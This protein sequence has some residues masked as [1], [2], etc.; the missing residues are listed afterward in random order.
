MASDLKGYYGGDALNSIDLFVLLDLMGGD[1][2]SFP[3]YFP[4]ATSKPYNMLATIGK[5]K[6]A[7]K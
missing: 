2:S 6:T 1:S 3:N 7:N 4:L 5:L